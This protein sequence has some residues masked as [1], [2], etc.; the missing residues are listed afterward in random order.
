MRRE[1]TTQVKTRLLFIVPYPELKE[2]AEFVIRNYPDRSRIEVDINVMT[3]EEMPEKIDVGHYDAVIARGYSAQK[4]RR[5]ADQVPVVGLEISGY[6]IVRAIMECK[7]LADPAKIAVISP[8]GPLYEVEAVCRYF[9]CR[10]KAYVATRHEELVQVVR[11]AREEGCEAVIGGYSVNLCAKQEG[12]PSVVIRTGEDTIQQ[13]LGEAVRIVEQIRKEQVVSQTY[14]TII[15]S[16][17]EGI[18]YVDDR[19]IIQVRNRVIREMEGNNSLMHRRLGE[20][21]PFFAEPFREA[22]ATGREVSGKIYTFPQTRITVSAEFTPVVVGQK[23]AGVVI[24]VSDIT[25]IQDLEG[26]IRRKLGEKGLRARHTF[27]DIIHE[28]AVMEQTIGQARRYAASEANVMIVGETGTGKELFAQSIHNASQRKNGPFVAINCAALPENL[29]E[30]ELFGYVEGAF[31]GTAKGGKMGLFEQAHGGTLFLDE[32]GEISPAIQ[33]KL[34]RALQER[35]VRRIGDD[36][37][38]SVNVRIISATN[39]NLKGLAERGNFRRDLMYRLDVLRLLIPPLRK[40]GT[41]AWLLFKRLLGERGMAGEGLPAM[42]AEALSMFRSYPFKGNIRELENVA[43]RITVLCQGGGISAADMEQILYP[44]DVADEAWD[45]EPGDLQA[46]AARGHDYRKGQH[47]GISE[48]ELILWG[49][50]QCQGN[51]SKAARLL[52]MDRSTLWRKR[53]KYGI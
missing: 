2:K 27:E 48:R 9:G 18:L 31:T 14:K 46:D 26:K 19:G 30:S 3:V 8:D 44:Q 35:E 7:E 15:Y 49:L 28:S 42:D 22:V 21:I 24:N 40:R 12:L 34:L 10:A 32:I 16:S 52:G 38:I 23:V 37:V 36:K 4:M 11:Q 29:L 39:K 20:V 51:Q 33:T 50:E 43:E 53:Q 5:I 25:K 6:D 47:S 17:K 13:A 41:D 1:G 45:E